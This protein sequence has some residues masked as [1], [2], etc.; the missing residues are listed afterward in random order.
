MLKYKNILDKLTQRQKIALVTD[1]SALS[2]AAIVRAGVPEVRWGE[3]AAFANEQG[4]SYGSL[5]NTWDPE[6]VEEFTESIAAVARGKGYKMLE[7]PD[8]KTVLDPYADGL[9]EDPYLNGALGGAMLR[10]IRNAGAAAA[11]S[12]FSVAERDVAYLD[13]AQDARAIHDLVKKPFAVATEIAPCDAICASLEGVK[14]GYQSVNAS[15]FGE[16]VNGGSEGTPFVY[17]RPASGLPDFHAFLEKGACVG[18]GEVALERALG[19]YDRLMLDRNEGS[20]TALEVQKAIDAGLAI[21]KET[22]EEAADRVIDF[23]FRANRIAPRGQSVRE[24]P[25]RNAA[26]ES[27]VLLKNAGLLPLARGTQIA[28][29]G[30]DIGFAKACSAF[31]LVGTARGN[32]AGVAQSVAIDEAVRATERAKAVVVFLRTQK[33]PSLQLPPDVLA[34]VS[35][36]T[37]TRKRLIAVLLGDF[38]ADPSFDLPFSAVLCAPWNGIGRA[39]AIAEVLAGKFVPCGRLARSVPD[40]ADAYYSVLKAD[41]EYG[42]TKVGPFV[43]YRYYDTIGYA[44]RYP[45]GY[46]LSYTHFRYSQLELKNEEVCFTVKNTGS[47]GGIETAQVYVGHPKGGALSPK[48]ELKA[49]ARISLQAGESKRVSIPLPRSRFASFDPSVMRESVEKGTYLVYVGS[50]VSDIRLRGTLSLDGESREP[51]KE[52]A[53]DYFRDLSN[54]GSNYRLGTAEGRSSL[55]AKTKWFRFGAMSVLFL[56]LLIAAI[57]GVVYLRSDSPSVGGMI[58]LLSDLTLSLF[59]VV[60]LIGVRRYRKKRLKEEIAEQK[61]NFPEARMV[62]TPGDVFDAVFAKKEAEAETVSKADEPYYFDKSFSFEVMAKELRLYMV[63]RGLFLEEK[64]I[65]A[66][67]AA[68]AASHR[69]LICPEDG[70]RLTRFFEFLCAYFGTAPH[71]EGVSSG[72]DDRGRKGTQYSVAIRAAMKDKS[73]ICLCLLRHTEGRVLSDVA[74]DGDGKEA[75]PE[76][77]FLIAETDELAGSVPECAAV[78][79]IGGREASPAAALT[80]VRPM[81]SYQFENLCRVVRDEFPL[82]ERL[83]KRVD[84]LEELCDANGGYRIPN[85]LW[86]KLEKHSSAYLACGGTPE[87]ALDSAVATELL[88][89]IAERLREGRTDDE[90]ISRLEEIFGGEQVGECREY[91]RQTEKKPTIERGNKKNG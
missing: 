70:K 27:I 5:A 64:E 13:V 78:L 62:T 65:R 44:V 6:L 63:E 46:G 8:L 28:V 38:P 35:A 86:I 75:L 51:I 56:T 1:L 7:T 45:F 33:G 48:K 52:C 23:A 41:K 87:E 59:A 24:D 22:L 61:L 37:R 3:L 60:A 68:F 73:R 71:I 80:E 32:D 11:L 82:D 26:R 58:F 67:I 50:S 21:D 29:I 54:I 91:I 77:L 9:S 85:R 18:G 14:N 66:L 47:Y 49:F 42:R 43:G 69:I 84:R 20:A 90:V 25:G 16:A 2:D 36:L 40:D 39:E 88:P 19:R 15:L 53:S 81:G 31:E 79:P 89:F 74:A 72:E 34:L 4:V 12:S 30:D 10:A 83:W 76:N 57:A 55:P 17:S